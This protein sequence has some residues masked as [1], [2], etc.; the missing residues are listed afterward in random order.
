[1]KPINLVRKMKVGSI[2]R[3]V[4]AQFSPK[5]HVTCS[6]RT[7]SLCVVC[8][9]HPKWISK[10]LCSMVTKSSKTKNKR[11]EGACRCGIVVSVEPNSA[12]RR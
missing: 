4:H 12:T 5:K 11:S 9:K 8:T 2:R 6:I 7:G 1:M 10:K 3:V